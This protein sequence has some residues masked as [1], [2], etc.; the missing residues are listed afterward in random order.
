MKREKYNEKTSIKDESKNIEQN[1]FTSSLLITNTHSHTHTHARL[2][3]IHWNS[4]ECVRIHLM[5]VLAHQHQ[6]NF[7]R[8]FGFISAPFWQRKQ[9]VCCWLLLATTPI[10]STLFMSNLK[11]YFIHTSLMGATY[12]LCPSRRQLFTARE[13]TFLHLK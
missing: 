10:K 2:S 5:F 4:I 6:T 9:L 3:F 13:N 1:V 11:K 12:L 7:I 8:I